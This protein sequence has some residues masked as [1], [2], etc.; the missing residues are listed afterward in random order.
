MPLTQLNVLFRQI[1]GVLPEELLESERDEH[2][3]YSRDEGRSKQTAN[4]RNG[5]SPKTVR[6]SQDEL[7]LKIPRDRQGEYEP[8]AV[9]KHQR[10][11]PEIADK[12][13]STPIP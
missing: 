7:E 6:S 3:G 9:E 13:I 2:L 10:D 12:I 8:Q 5:Y 11:I 4:S 1:T